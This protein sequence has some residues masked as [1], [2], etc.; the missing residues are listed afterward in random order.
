MTVQDLDSA[1]TLTAA[2]IAAYLEHMGV[3]CPSCLSHDIEGAAIVIDEGHAAQPMKCNFCDLEW[4]DEYE[5]ST[6][7]NVK[8]GRQIQLFGGSPI[9]TN[10]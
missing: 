8:F 4:S 3:H 1:R 7:V 6:V 10:A 9:D 2:Q 5:L